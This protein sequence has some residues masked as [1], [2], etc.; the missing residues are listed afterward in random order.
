MSYMYKKINSWPI[1][2]ERNVMITYTYFKFGVKKTSEKYGISKNRI[3]QI[4]RRLISILW[5]QRIG[6]SRYDAIYDK[7]LYKSKDR[8]EMVKNYYLSI[9]NKDI[10]DVLGEEDAIS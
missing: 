10:D 4:Y 9:F 2:H 6:I 1:H 7:K 5:E 8:L 3:Y